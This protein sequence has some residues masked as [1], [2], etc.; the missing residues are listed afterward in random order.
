MTKTTM[1][2]VGAILA[3][4]TAAQAGARGSNG[5]YVNTTS[6]SAGGA[7]ADARNDSST[8]T[9]VS[10]QINGGPTYQSAVASFTD[11]SGVSAYCWSSNAQV[12]GILARAT[13]DAQ[14]YVQW[15]ANGQC[16]SVTVGNDSAFAPKV[17]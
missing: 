5:T 4:A 7:M 13:N 1:M 3:M 2:V 17:P 10:I 9:R 16:T 8:K 6:R 12:V 15:D 14:V 11:Y